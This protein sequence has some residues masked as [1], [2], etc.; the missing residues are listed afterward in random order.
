MT[1]IS[2]ILTDPDLPRQAYRIFIKAINPNEINH[3]LFITV[4]GTKLDLRLTP[5]FLSAASNFS[6]FIT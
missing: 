5:E 2:I 4:C 1:V 3:L 6:C